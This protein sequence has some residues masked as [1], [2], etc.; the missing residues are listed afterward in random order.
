M[1]L[2]FIE[3][4]AHAC[5]S[6]HTFVDDVGLRALPSLCIASCSC[7]SRARMSLTRDMVNIAPFLIVMPSL[8]SRPGTKLWVWEGRQVG[9]IVEVE[10]SL[11]RRLYGLA[12]R[13]KRWCTWLNVS[14]CLWRCCR[15]SSCIARDACLKMEHCKH[16]CVLCTCCV[17]LLSRY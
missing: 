6:W 11:W 12:W 17:Q 2:T 15:C 14:L 1:P 13:I 7:C 4:V 9:V 3:R 5:S 16:Y 10:V 8:A